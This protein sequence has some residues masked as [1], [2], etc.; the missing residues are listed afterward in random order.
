[1]LAWLMQNALAATILAIIVAI[2][3]RLFRPHPAICHVLW[4]V[5]LL[6]LIMPPLPLWRASA[7]DRLFEPA[8]ARTLQQDQRVV[9]SDASND[10]VPSPAVSETSPTES[11]ILQ[12]PVGSTWE[13]LKTS[14]E[15]SP[16]VL[17]DERST[18]PNASVPPGALGKT[19]GNVVDSKAVRADASDSLPETAEPP[20]TQIFDRAALWPLATG[21]I[22]WLWASGVLIAFARHV[23]L[24]SCIRRVVA[25]SAGAPDWLRRE[26]GIQSCKSRLAWPRV[27]L[28]TGLPCPMVIALPRATLLWPANLAERLD[29]AA[30]CAVLAHE[31]AHLK[32]R[33]H[34][35]AWLEVVVACLWW[36]HPVVWWARRE[37]RHYAELACD[38][39]VVDHSPAERG[40][41]AKALV[42]VCEFISLAKP[43][44]APAVGMARGHR[45]RFERRLQMIL[46]QRIAARVP[47]IAWVG[48]LAA[49][50]LVL[51]GFST[52][53][54]NPLAT[55]ESKT[56][57]TVKQEDPKAL[58][59]IK[60]APVNVATEPATTESVDVPGVAANEPDAKLTVKTGA[61]AS[62]NEQ[63]AGELSKSRRE[64]QSLRGRGFDAGKETIERAAKSLAR[65]AEHMRARKTPDDYLVNE[66]YLHVLGRMPDKNELRNWRDTLKF[67][68][69]GI[70]Q[71]VATLVDS[72]EFTK[73]RVTA[74]TKRSVSLPPPIRTAKVESLLRV[75][76]EM[77]ADKAEAL[78]KFLKENVHGEIEARTGEEGLVVTA[79]LNAQRTIAGI[80]SLMTGQPVSLGLGDTPTLAPAMRPA[81]YEESHDPNSDTTPYSAATRSVRSRRTAVFPPLPAADESI[82]EAVEQ[83][84]PA[85]WSSPA[86]R[87][88]GIRK[89][90]TKG[91]VTAEEAPPTPRASVKELPR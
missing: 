26:V 71:M 80:V 27:R 78:A 48:I 59:T 72:S 58:P 57:T 86:A 30:R 64:L 9:V 35:T 18:N 36:W 17:R 44:R 41:Y 63:I 32:R 55:E 25:D 60:T 75:T 84:G 8:I 24:F 66:V 33:D 39:W 50:L 70:E 47:L 68:D 23:W 19:A 20:A 76:Y 77:P 79:G 10:Q 62:V 7:I 28:C 13:G 69:G 82:P 46:R 74:T 73:P 16:E 22:A 5:V 49:A 89:A 3:C 87:E 67:G 65:L 14:P 12:Q 34:W 38:A 81:A 29:D 53:Q 11:V 4:L 15:L 91:P 45:R 56:P 88:Y 90:A 40:L 83:A 51:P 1:M 61:S 21:A 42:D 54:D 52:G 43:A 37:L 6:K 85:G 31:L 2:A